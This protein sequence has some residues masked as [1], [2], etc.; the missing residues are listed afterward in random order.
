MRKGSIKI[1]PL[2]KVGS[3]CSD[4]TEESIEKTL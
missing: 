4:S 2:M 3:I 1:N